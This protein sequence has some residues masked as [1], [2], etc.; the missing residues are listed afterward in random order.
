MTARDRKP[1][2]IVLDAALRHTL[3]G[4]GFESRGRN[5]KYFKLPCDGFEWFVAFGPGPSGLEREGFTDATCIHSEEVARLYREVWGAPPMRPLRIRHEAIYLG[6]IESFAEEARDKFRNRVEA[7]SGWY[8]ALDWMNGQA[9]D[10]ELA[11]Q[12]V[13]S[14]LFWFV[15]GLCEMFTH[16]P[17][18][19]K[20]HVFEKETPCYYGFLG[21]EKPLLGR[22]EF[23]D[24][25]GIGYS[26]G[27]GKGHYWDTR[28][29]DLTDLGLYLDECWWRHCLPVVTELRDIGAVADK[30]FP[31]DTKEPMAGPYLGSA[32]V[33]HVAGHTDTVRAVLEVGLRESAV[34]WEDFLGAL[35]HQV[36]PKDYEE[37][38]NTPHRL[39]NVRAQWEARQRLGDQSR[40]MAKAMGVRL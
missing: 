10:R 13:R 22:A 20:Y 14:N 35:N 28:G 6:S 32:F 40:K 37:I 7:E 9:H 17:K 27:Y 2:D 30:Y 24:K 33:H 31:I 12:R 21:K 15:Y 26:G 16:H 34:S 3:H 4:L 39:S 38:V 11:G 5:A 29:R 23:F 8:Q 25:W 18:G 1:V 19:L 36:G